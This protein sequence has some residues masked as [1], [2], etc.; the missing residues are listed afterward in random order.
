MQLKAKL[1][2]PE[3]IHII[4]D[5]HT[6]GE[7]LAMALPRPVDAIHASDVLGDIL[8]EGEYLT[9]SDL[10][11]RLA[12]KAEREGVISFQYTD[13]D[14]GD[15]EE[16]PYPRLRLWVRE[17]GT[18]TLT[19]VVRRLTMELIIKTNKPIIKHNAAVRKLEER[20]ALYEKL[21]LEFE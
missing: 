14:F 15:L 10:C 1:S 16:A 21:K 6:D 4:R 2:K 7:L 12:K 11:D 3:A 9:L 18:E 20:K 17:A 5:T 19:Q 13:E 8:I